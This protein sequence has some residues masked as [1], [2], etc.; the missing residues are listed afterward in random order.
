M[1]ENKPTQS[2]NVVG[3]DLAGRDIHHHYGEH[4]RSFM[5]SLI[6]SLEREQKERREF[7]EL[8][9]TLRHYSSSVD[10]TELQG[11]TAKLAAADRQDCVA[12]AAGLKEVFAKQIDRHQLFESAQM[13]LA[14]ALGRM[15]DNFERSIRPLLISKTPRHL[16]D[17]AIVSEVLEPVMRELED[18]PLAIDTTVLRGGMFFLTGN[19]HLRWAA[20]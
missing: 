12:E 18:N 2:G 13:I 4:T 16:V 8:I 17:A 7:K 20:S 10:N 9:A 11:L 6:E 5:R 19:C 1:S 3:R 15:K 14:Y